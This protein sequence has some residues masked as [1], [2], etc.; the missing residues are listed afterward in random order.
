MEGR[1]TVG[2]IAAA[3]V[4]RVS[5]RTLSD[6]SAWES[7]DDVSVPTLLS[8][9]HILSPP[10]LPL[11]SLQSVHTRFGSRK[12]G[13]RGGGGGEETLVASSRSLSGNRI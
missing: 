1:G 13:W 10:S 12:G 7:A 5:T 4:G 3:A 2:V 8:A 6:I 9:L 11:N